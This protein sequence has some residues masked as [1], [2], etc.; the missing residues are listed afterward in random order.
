LR[1]PR[2]GEEYRRVLESTLEEILSLTTIV[3]NLL[4]LAKADQEL[5]QPEFS[6]VHVRALLAELYEDCEILAGKKGITLHMQDIPDAIMV[7]DRV[8]LRQMLLNLVDNAI[9]YTAPGGSVSIGMHRRDGEAIVT[10]RDT[11]IGISEEHIEKIFDRFYRVDKA[12]ARELGGTGLGLS[13]ARWIAELH[14]GRLT[15]ESTPRV[16]STFTVQLPLR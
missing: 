2:S 15:V 3:E 14:R 13:I 9:K 1:H 8:R 12:R 7:G 16:G 10:V 5:S 4:T 6:Q 11:G